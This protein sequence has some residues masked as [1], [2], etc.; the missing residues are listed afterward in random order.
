MST[1]NSNDIHL[2][3][4]K[5][6]K[7]ICTN[8]K[9]LWL[10]WLL[11]AQW[12]QTE[13]LSRQGFYLNWP[14]IAGQPSLKSITGNVLGSKDSQQVLTTPPI[15]LWLLST[16]IMLAAY[17][18][19]TSRCGSGCITTLICMRITQSPWADIDGHA[20]CLHP[21]LLPDL[22]GILSFLSFKS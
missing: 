20:C 22:S 11:S 15:K 14:G 8:K 7:P 5:R 4:L 2:L 10:V 3:Y 1:Q 12:S 9:A 19:Y 18:Q 6:T 16:N 21:T 13:S 17:T